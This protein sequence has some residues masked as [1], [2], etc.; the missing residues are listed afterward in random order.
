[1]PPPEQTE[2]QR[3]MKALQ[4]CMQNANK[5]Y[6]EPAAQLENTRMKLFYLRGEL[7]KKLK[8]WKKDMQENK[9]SL[10]KTTRKCEKQHRPTN[11]TSIQ[12]L[13]K[14]FSSFRK[15]PVADPKDNGEAL[16]LS[17]ANS[18]K[19]AKQVKAKPQIYPVDAPHP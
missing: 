8:A 7:S 10:Y 18:I 2:D 12:R 13:V 5:E 3:R 14:M 1:M 15:S 9:I 4:V 16:K 17:I 11:P 6:D 19:F